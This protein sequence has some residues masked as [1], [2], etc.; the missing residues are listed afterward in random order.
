M[1]LVEVVTSTRSFRDTTSRISLMR[2]SIWPF[3]GLT[4]TSG[5]SSPVGRTPAQPPPFPTSPA[6]RRRAWPKRKWSGDLLLELLEGERPVIERRGQPETIV[7]QSLL[8]RAVAGVHGSDLRY[9]GVRLVYH[10]EEV[11]REEVQQGV[12]GCPGALPVRCRE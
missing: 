9:A 2:S 7:N 8:P 4:S 10:H 3:V 5:S 11:P 6:R 1:R 12:G